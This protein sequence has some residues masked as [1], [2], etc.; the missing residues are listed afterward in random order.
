MNDHNRLGDSVDQDDMLP[1]YDLGQMG[2]AIV[3]KYAERFR[4]GTNLAKLEPDV[5]AAF[6]TDAAVNDALRSLLPPPLPQ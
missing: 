3:G 4:Q 1:E 2:P 5:R 6:P